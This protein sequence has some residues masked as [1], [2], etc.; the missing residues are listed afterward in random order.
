MVTWHFLLIIHKYWKSTRAWPILKSNF[1]KFQC[2][3]KFLRINNKKFRKWGPQGA[4][5]LFLYEVSIVVLNYLTAILLTPGIFL[6]QIVNTNMYLLHLHSKN[7]IKMHF[8]KSWVFKGSNPLQTFI[9][10]CNVGNKLHWH[11]QSLQRCVTGIS[12][13]K[14]INNYNIYSLKCWQV[15][16]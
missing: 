13:T 5:L 4:P 7:N 6:I 10:H 11:K 3:K 16:W 8:P 2:L 15:F 1:T 14:W 9:I 12:K